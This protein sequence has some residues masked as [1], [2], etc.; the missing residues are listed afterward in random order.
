MTDFLLGCSVLVLSLVSGWAVAQ[1]G[2]Q[3]HSSAQPQRV[4][5]L[6]ESQRERSV[7]IAEELWQLAEMGYLETRSSQSLKDYLGEHEFDVV[8]KVA[9]IPTAFVATYGSGGPT[10]AILA[11]LEC[12]SCCWPISIVP[13]LLVFVFQMRVILA[14]FHLTY[15]S[16]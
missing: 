13:S 5:E 3:G 2:S 12:D 14:N 16:L 10:I 7:A 11:V 6:V 8:Q 9:D 1:S 4:I 15:F